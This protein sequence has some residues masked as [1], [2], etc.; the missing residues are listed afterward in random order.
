MAQQIQEKSE[1]TR[2]W[3]IIDTYFTRLRRNEDGQIVK[4]G[5]DWAFEPIPQ[6]DSTY[7]RPWHGSSRHPRSHV[8]DESFQTKEKTRGR[9]P[10]SKFHGDRLQ[11]TLDD[12]HTTGPLVAVDSAASSPPRRPKQYS[13]HPKSSTSRAKQSSSRA[14]QIKKENIISQNPWALLGEDE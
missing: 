7:S 4:V 5:P 14:K 9:R 2:D 6:D 13:S 8:A 10:S 11:S 1:A 12:F 3:G